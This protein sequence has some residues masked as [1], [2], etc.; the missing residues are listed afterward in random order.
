VR[1]GRCGDAAAALGTHAVEP[2]AHLFVEFR[3]TAER[4]VQRRF[5]R[6]DERHLAL[7][8]VDRKRRVEAE[9]FAC[10]LGTEAEAF[11][12]LALGVLGA[13]EQD[14]S[15]TVFARAGVQH[16]Q[17]LGLGKARQVVEVAVVP[18][19]IVGVPVT[20]H[21]RRSRDDGDASARRAQRS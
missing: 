11:P 7:D 10:S 17:P 21:F 15:R 5:V 4:V 18:V 9:R 13:A 20:H 16:E 14:R 1:G 12:D 8:F 3:R 2:A 6:E 19:G